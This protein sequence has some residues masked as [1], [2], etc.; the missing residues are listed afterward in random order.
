MQVSKTIQQYRANSIFETYKNTA[1]GFDNLKE[2]II[3]S[4]EKIFHDFNYSSEDF[5]I[6]FNTFEEAYIVIHI[7][8]VKLNTQIIKPLNDFMGVEGVIAPSSGVSFQI[9]YSIKCPS[10]AQSLLV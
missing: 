2:Q 1:E 8:E 5:R 10:I 6:Y 4:I 3:E 9:I 7:D